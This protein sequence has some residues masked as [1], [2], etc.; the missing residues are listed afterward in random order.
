MDIRAR[1]LTPAWNKLVSFLHK[2]VNTY[3]LRIM[4]IE[5]VD[6]PDV[7]LIADFEVSIDQLLRANIMLADVIQEI[8]APVFL[9]EENIYTWYLSC[10]T[11]TEAEYA[12]YC[13]IRLT[14]FCKSLPVPL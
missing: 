1:G 14:V 5:S 7:L 4:G 2:K 3:R 13:I 6:T 10:S 11:T 12:G 9:K 8:L